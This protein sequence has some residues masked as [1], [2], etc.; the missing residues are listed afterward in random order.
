MEIIV[1][2]LEILSQAKEEIIDRYG[3]VRDEL[4]IT[5]N[6]LHLNSV[7]DQRLAELDRQE[8]LQVDN[9]SRKICSVSALKDSFQDLQNNIDKGNDPATS[10]TLDQYSKWQDEMNWTETDGRKI[11]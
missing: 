5:Q 10:K 11:A 8:K 9:I 6:K 2:Q 4:I 7:F 3:D 1:S